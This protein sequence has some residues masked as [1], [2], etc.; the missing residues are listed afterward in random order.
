MQDLSNH[1]LIY[2]KSLI[3]PAH[4]TRYIHT[5][6]KFLCLIKQFLYQTTSMSESPYDPSDSLISLELTNQNSVDS[7]EPDS[8]E[9][10]CSLVF[11]NGEWQMPPALYPHQVIIPLCLL[12]IQNIFSI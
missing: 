11:R 10:S 2:F 3:P 1:P 12:Q 8:P 4:G 9:S 5:L 6:C 7:D